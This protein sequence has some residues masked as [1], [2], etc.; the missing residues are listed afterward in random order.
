MTFGPINSE[1]PYLPTTLKFEN[2]PD[3]LIPQLIRMYT[4]IALRL[5]NRE[6][7]LYDLQERL[8]G[9]KW[10]DST[11][12]QTPKETFRKVFDFGSIAPGATLNISHGI[13]TIARF[14]NFYGSFTTASDDRPLPYV[15]E[16]TVTNQVSVK[17]VGA[18]IVII[19]GST[20]PSINSGSL[21][22]EYLKN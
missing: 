18:N 21:V 15:D 10:T 16:A 1:S 8:T 14:T 17:R 2:N 4:N 11:N 22:V 3:I 13:N 20:A 6:I 12:L 7:S 9:Q 19:N 5:N